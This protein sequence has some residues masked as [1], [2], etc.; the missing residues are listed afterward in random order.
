[1]NRDNR[2]YLTAKADRLGHLVHR[3]EIE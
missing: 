2:A 3:E 1:V